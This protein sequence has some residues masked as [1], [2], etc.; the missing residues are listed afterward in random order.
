MSQ[1]TFEFL[2][3]AVSS[4]TN[5]TCRA[6]GDCYERQLPGG[7]RLLECDPPGPQRRYIREWLASDLPS[8]TWLNLRG[9]AES[10]RGDLGGSGDRPR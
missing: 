9:N 4:S 5:N 1:L 7:S 3:H 10:R 8:E 6:L 2:F